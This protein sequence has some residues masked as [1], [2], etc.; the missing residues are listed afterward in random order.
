ME[1]CQFFCEMLYSELSR[2]FKSST[3]LGLFFLDFLI[4]LLIFYVFISASTKGTRS[5]NGGACGWNSSGLLQERMFQGILWRELLV[6]EGR[7]LLEEEGRGHH[8][9]G[10]LGADGLWGAGLHATR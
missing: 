9:V 5:F 3:I 1:Q 8:G 2:F 10:V 4:I 6:E 7:V